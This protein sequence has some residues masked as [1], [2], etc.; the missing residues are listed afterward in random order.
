MLITACVPRRQS[1][2]C[3]FLET[4]TYYFTLLSAAIWEFR[5]VG[6]QTCI[7]TLGDFV[8]LYPQSKELLHPGL[9]VMLWLV[10]EDLLH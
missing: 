9:C 4:H 6:N 2:K 3:F 5:S 8:L 7:S 1:E 10:F